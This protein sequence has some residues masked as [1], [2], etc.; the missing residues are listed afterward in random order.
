VVPKVDAKGNYISF[1]YNL[2]VRRIKA[3]VTKALKEVNKTSIYLNYYIPI[4]VKILILKYV[5]PKGEGNP[6]INTILTKLG[7]LYLNT[8]YTFNDI[9]IL[10]GTSI[11]TLI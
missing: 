11:I 9:S 2:K 5:F 10:E 6:S 8:S 3:L 7:I 4:A 1:I